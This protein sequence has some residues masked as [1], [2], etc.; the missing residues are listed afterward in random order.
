[1]ACSTD[2]AVSIIV[3]SKGTG[4][5]SNVFKVWLTLPLYVLPIKARMP[6]ISLLKLDINFNIKFG[7]TFV[8]I[9]GYPL[10]FSNWAI[11]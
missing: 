8:L 10:D 7:A 1:M 11:S 3:L 4:F 2:A 6:F 5:Q 9:L